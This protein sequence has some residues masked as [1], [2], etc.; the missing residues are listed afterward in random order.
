M[1]KYSKVTLIIE[2]DEGKTTIDVPTAI[3]VVLEHEAVQ[4]FDHIVDSHRVQVQPDMMDISLRMRGFF[5]E[6]ANYVFGLKSE[7]KE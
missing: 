3:D 2:N 7:P 4:T 6:N 1:T 5:N